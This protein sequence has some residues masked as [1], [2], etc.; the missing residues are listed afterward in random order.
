MGKNKDI[1][2]AIE[3]GMVMRSGKLVSKD[4]ILVLRPREN[5]L[6]CH[7]CGDLITESLVDQHIMKCQYGKAECGKCQEWVDGIGFMEH[8][9]N[10]KGTHE[11]L[12][13]NRKRFR[14]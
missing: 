11:V 8:Y 4:R 13:G 6:R 10:C 3:S 2:R 1:Q 12:V 7:K 5:M 9:R 14:I